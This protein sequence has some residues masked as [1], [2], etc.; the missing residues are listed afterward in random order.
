MNSLAGIIGNVIGFVILFGVVIWVFVDAKAIGSDQGRT[1]KLLNTY[2]RLWAAGVFLFLIV[3]LPLYLL[4]RIRY[5][6]IAAERRAV[7][8]VVPNGAEVIE[9]EGVWPP[10]P[11]QPTA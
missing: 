3:V 10:P 7:L 6:R 11:Q 4:M 2:P 5:K 9:T 8:A 1:P